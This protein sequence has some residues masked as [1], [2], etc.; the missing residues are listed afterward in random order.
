MLSTKDMTH[1]VKNPGQ[2]SD[3]EIKTILDNWNVPEWSDMVPEEF[4]SR[5][6]KSEFHILTGSASNMLSVARIN[7]HFK[8]KF[9]D[10]V[11]QIAEL[12]GF[13]AVEILKGYGK[14][15]LER[16]IDNLESRNI[17][18]IGFCKNKNSTY[19]ESC[20]LRIFYNS[21]QFL[22]EMKDGKWFTPTEDDDIFNLTLSDATIP[23]FEKLSHDHPAYLIFE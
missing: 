19:Y 17:E 23:L 21:V 10:S 22:R 11:Y 9:D 15:L 1:S 18:A 13:V 2:L 5:F 3:V 6:K 4:K 7:F 20:G 16:I 12:V 8:V 14:M